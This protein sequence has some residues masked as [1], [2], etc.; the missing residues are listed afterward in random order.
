MH[1]QGTTQQ[2]LFSYTYLP[3]LATLV[4]D[5]NADDSHALMKWF[6]QSSEPKLLDLE[7]ATAIALLKPTPP[8]PLLTAVPDANAAAADWQPAF[9][10]CTTGVC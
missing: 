2:G 6:F 8:L 4:A 9:E 7:L 3:L 1:M 5:A 10:G